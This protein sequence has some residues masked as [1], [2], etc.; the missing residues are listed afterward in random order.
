M[1]ET[2]AADQLA[3]EALEH[4]RQDQFQAALDGFMEAAELYRSAGQPVRAAEMANNSAVTLLKMDR[5]QEAFDVL[6]GTT[7]IFAEA[8][9]QRLQ[10]QSIGNEAAA[11]EALDRPDAALALYNRALTIFN[12]I[13]DEEARSYTLQAIS[14][15]QLKSGQA[16]QA[17]DS[18]Q[19]ALDARP[20]RGFLGRVIQAIM[21]LPTRWLNR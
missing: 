20:R 13:D 7:E 1:N 10:A 18:M 8:G 15:L 21:R 12:E 9:E 5:P 17:L 6:S 11:Y 14:R 4:F 16:L 3:E 2:E 19:A